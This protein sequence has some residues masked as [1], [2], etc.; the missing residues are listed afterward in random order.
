MTGTYTEPPLVVDV[1][2]TLIKTDLLHE[3]LLQFAARSPLQLWRVPLWL[4]GG[5]HRMKC[6]LAAQVPLDVASLPV[7]REVLDRIHE[8]Q[9]EGRAVYLASASEQRL[10]QRLADQIGGIEGVFG[11]DP[12]GNV[13]GAR[14][15]DT[16]NAAFGERRYDYIG[17]RQVD[18]AVWR[19]ARRVLAVSHSARFSRHLIAAFPDAEIVARSHHHPRAYLNAMR[20]HQWAKNILVFLSLLAGHQFDA[21]TM[22]NAV[23]AFVCFCFAASSAYVINDLLD[24]PADRLHHRKKRRP[25]A[26]GDMPVSHGVVLG[27]MLMMLAFGGAALLSGSFL[28]TLAIYVVL[29]LAYSLFLK[30]ELLIDI[31]MLGGLYTIRIVGGIAAGNTHYSPWLL[32]FSLFFFMSL[33]TLKRCSELIAHRNPDN[34]SLPGRSYQTSDL[35]ILLPLGAAAGY[36][37]V[38]VIGL[39]L[40]SDDIRVLYAHPIRMWLICPVLLYWISRMLVLCNRDQLHDDPLIFALTDRVSWFTALIAALIV[41]VSI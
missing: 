28:A 38:L 25:L 16:L 1:D 26:A 32:M 36:G 7:R 11:T 23:L 37:A 6:A 29:T 39:Y 9:A 21:T 13:A 14:K 18:F 17:D 27:A 3:N 10:V 4:T 15:A 19:S 8:A 12:S 20:P 33:A 22:L 40:A 24:L 35:A 30:R 5:R 2:G 41:A 31:V 34:P